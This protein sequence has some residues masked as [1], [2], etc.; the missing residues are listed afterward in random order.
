M[1]ITLAL[2]Q[3]RDLWAVAITPSTNPVDAEQLKFECHSHSFT[4]TVYRDFPVVTAERG[5]VFEQFGRVWKDTNG[6]T[7]IKYN[8]VD[9]RV[10]RAKFGRNEHG[11]RI[12]KL[13]LA[14][15]EGVIPKSRLPLMEIK[16][17]DP[18][19]DDKVI[20]N[21]IICKK[22]VLDIQ[23]MRRDIELEL[24]IDSK[25]SGSWEWRGDGFLICTETINTGKNHKFV[26]GV[27]NWKRFDVTIEGMNAQIAA[28]K[29]DD[30]F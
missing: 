21:T 11:E 23:T 26:K 19:F 10:T 29:E 8:G 6:K 22:N 15:V 5:N 12:Q 13:W 24:H 7:T 3:F 17:E 20:L 28:D 9:A 18:D 16:V 2:P 27:K 14:E 4:L 30:H 25:K 1:H